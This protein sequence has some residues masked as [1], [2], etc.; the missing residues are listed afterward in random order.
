MKIKQ[1][2]AHFLYSTGNY[3]NERIGFT[4]EID[5]ETESIEAVVAALRL[6]ARSVVGQPAD[7]HYS[8]QQQAEYAARNAKAKLDKLRQEWEATA[9]FLRAQGINPEAPSMPQFQ[10]LLAAAHLEGETVLDGELTDVV[11]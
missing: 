9:A 7:D 4:V 8:E 2:H 1:I 3:C 5:Q 6:Q 11:L 10:S